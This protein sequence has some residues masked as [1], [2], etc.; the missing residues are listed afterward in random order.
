[1]LRFT[2][3]PASPLTEVLEQVRS[4]LEGLSYGSVEI[5]VHS[6]R[7]VQIE[8]REKVRL[9]SPRTVSNRH[10]PIESA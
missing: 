7:I 5:T 4:A 2:S 3:S 6:G 1:M 8:R 9:E 10:N